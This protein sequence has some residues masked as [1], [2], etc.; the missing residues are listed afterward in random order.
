MT[1]E[2]RSTDRLEGRHRIEFDAFSAAP[3]ARPE[4]PAAGGYHF[5]TRREVAP[6]ETLRR[7][8]PLLRRAGI[9]RLADVTGL[10]WIGI[11]V[12]QAIRP[13]SRNLSV[14]QGKGLTRTQAKVSAL[15]ESL[16]SF[17][18]ERIE[19]QTSLR[20]SVSELRP[21]L[22][23]DPRTLS[24]VREPSVLDPDV[25]PVRATHRHADGAAR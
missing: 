22:G 16:E 9:T 8:R 24:V 5:G 7:I 23:Y 17:H 1:A 20:A 6:A 25:R 4:S 15:M 14:A 11:P 18:A 3:L 12:Y 13:N 10:D 2:L 21:R 19:Y